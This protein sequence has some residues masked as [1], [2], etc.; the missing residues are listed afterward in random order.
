MNEAS[1]SSDQNVVTGVSPSFPGSY[2]LKGSKCVSTVRIAASLAPALSYS[3]RS[4][5]DGDGARWIMCDTRSSKD[6]RG[7]R[8]G[9][10]KGV[11]N[12]LRGLRVEGEVASFTLRSRC[13]PLKRRRW[14]RPRALLGREVSMV[15][16]ATIGAGT[17][18]GACSGLGGGDGW[19]DSVEVRLRKRSGVGG[20]L[21]SVPAVWAMRGSIDRT[22]VRENEASERTPDTYQDHWALA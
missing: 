8:V 17:S 22:E 3:G 4:A 19:L 20:R 14:P 15:G 13:S 11:K 2:S 7:V 5:C 16:L 21:N 18:S 9:D 12:A 10:R 1:L 6:V